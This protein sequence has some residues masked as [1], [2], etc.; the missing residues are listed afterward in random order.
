L[1]AL[2]AFGFEVARTRGSHATVRRKVE[3]RVQLLTV[4]LHKAL[5]QG[6]LRAIYRQACRF[7]HEAQLRP[8]FFTD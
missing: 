5:A 7:I 8:Y 3:G 6:T 4:P 2:A 1:R